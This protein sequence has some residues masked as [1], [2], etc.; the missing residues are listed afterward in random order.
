MK[1]RNGRPYHL[2]GSF[3]KPPNCNVNHRCTNIFVRT[4]AIRADSIDPGAKGMADPDFSAAFS[5]RLKQMGV[6]QPHPTFSPSSTAGSPSPDAAHHFP[7]PPGNYPS[8]ADNATLTVLQARRQLQERA[9]LE[10][11]GM[12]RPGDKGKEFLDVGTIRDVLALR[13]RGEAAGDIEARLG[14]R[15]G[16]VDRLGARGVVTSVGDAGS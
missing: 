13:Q 3:F 16:V 2:R 5:E 7:P 1:V 9:E 10:F 12:G 14:L 4:L 8:A 6:A 15:R 11:E